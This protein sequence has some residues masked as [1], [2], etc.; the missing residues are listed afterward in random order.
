MSHWFSW[1]IVQVAL[2]ALG[3]VTLATLLYH[4]GPMRIYIAAIELGPAGIV[5]IFLPS[6][7]MYLLDCVGWRMTLGAHATAIPFFQLFMIRTA[8]E[9]VNATT[10]T[11][12]VGGEPVKAY[13][14]A[15]C[16]IPMADGFASVIIAK[17]TMTIAQVA[18]ILIG[19]SLGFWFLLSSGETPDHPL[20]ISAIVAGLGLVLFGAALFIIVQRRGFFTV[21]FALL[22]KCRIR[23][24]PLEA[25]REK[26]FALDHAIV[27]FYSRSRRAFLLSTVVFLF[28]WLA[29]GI[30]VYL[31]LRY[32]GAPIDLLT[33]LSI[34]AISTFIKGATFVVPGSVGAQEAGNLM[35]VEAYGH[36][37]VIGM[38]F[39]LLRRLRELVWIAIGIV[40]LVLLKNGASS[41]RSKNK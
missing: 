33:A 41:G 6:M 15:Q 40:C 28:G 34:D 22:Q 5:I 18:Y 8:G 19:I 27:A 2:F 36:S 30:E 17:T 31:M 3:L 9:V 11:G 23:I 7:V 21:V 13:L 10:P 4:I 25:R 20:T 26:L 16:G 37:E 1:R 32:L 35:L 24:A 39:A 12:S 38:T 29:E 14:L